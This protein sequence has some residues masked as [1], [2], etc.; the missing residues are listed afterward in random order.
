MAERGDIKGGIVDGPFGFDNAISKKAAQMKGIKSEI[1]G[2]ANIIVAPNIEAANMC[3]K[4]IIYATGFKNGGVIVGSKSPIILLSRA[5]DAETK[6]NS[7]LLALSV[8]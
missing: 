5:D 7:I 6:L 3:A 2:E 4:G 1:A 8:I